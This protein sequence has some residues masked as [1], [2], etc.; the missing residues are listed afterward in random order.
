MLSRI[1]RDERGVALITA[2]LTSAIVVLLGTTVVNLAIHN[3]EGSAYDRRRVQAIGAAESGL[4]YYMSFLTA[5]G[6]QQLA[7]AGAAM[8]SRPMVGSPGRFEISPTFYSPTGAPMT[9]PPDGPPGAVLIRS[10]GYAGPTTNE[11]ARTM[12]A[13]AR[14]TISTGGTFD[15]SGA[16]IAN[17][18]VN[19]NA[20]ATIGGSNF[21]DADVYSSGSVSLASN[22]TLYGAIYAQGT[23]SMSSGSEVK[24]SVSAKGTITMQSASIIRGSA[25]ATG[26][27]NANISMHNNA[28]VYGDATASGVANGGAVDGTRSSGVTGLAPPPVRPYPVFVYDPVDWMEA[29]FT[30]PGDF[31]GPS[32]CTNAETYIRSTWTT[33][34]LL[35]RITAPGST[36]TLTF[37]NNP[38]SVKGNL[39][40]ISNGPVRFSTGARFSISGAPVN[41]F[42]IAGLSGIAPCD[43]TMN[44]NSGF[45]PGTT[46]MIYTP[47]NCTANLTSNTAITEGQ[48]LAGTVNF[49]HTAQFSYKRLTVP[50]TGAGGFKQDVFYKREI[51]T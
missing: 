43:I 44:T 28:H 48:I 14:L 7:C 2:V 32:A 51:I 35:V 39:A 8:L 46:T 6:G 36:C 30:N 25:T 31:S 13:Y 38:Y 5:T 34:N 50:G 16:I 15:N 24:K 23:V 4:D 29:G 37:G 1:H 42:L 33:G 10:T 12:E 18:S 17:N 45:G 40:I 21:S 3:S 27:P 11:I 41:V 26:P 9:C 47:Q 49:H 22:S 20:N 19:F